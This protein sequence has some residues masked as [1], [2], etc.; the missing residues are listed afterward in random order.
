MARKIDLDRGNDTRSLL[1]DMIM[2]L[3]DTQVERIYK[4]LFARYG[5]TKGSHKQPYNPDGVIDKENGYVLLTKHQFKSLLTKYGENYVHHAFKEWQNY[6]IYLKEH[7]DF[8]DK[9]GVRY[10]YKYEQYMK[11]T[12]I[13]E[14]SEGG[15]IYTNNK[16]YIHTVSKEVNIQVNPYLIN[17]YTVARKYVESLSIPMRSNPDVMFLVRKFPELADLVYDVGS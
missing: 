4:E 12:H 17:D 6:L 5:A 9:Q 2:N 1:L 10:G 11:R 3:S 14:L 16:K 7:P 15:W 13:K 8:K